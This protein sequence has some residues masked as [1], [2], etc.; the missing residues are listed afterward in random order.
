MNLLD[1]FWPAGNRGSILVTTRDKAALGQFTAGIREVQKLEEK[2][3]VD[4][5]M[6]LSR[7]PPGPLEHENAAKICARV[8]YLPLA[9]GA[10]AFI[11]HSDSLSFAEYLS[12]YS[13]RDLIVESKPLG[14][15]TT[16][17]AHSLASVWNMNFTRLDKETRFL[18]DT[19]AFLDPDK[20]QEDLVAEGASKCG[21]PHLKFLGSAKK[22]LHYRGKLCHSILVHRN[23]RLKQIWIQRLVQESCHIRMD[24]TTR[25]VAFDAA[26]HIV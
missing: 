13:N 12:G 24:K 7:Q 4:L 5:L 3:A 23:P 16:Q 20:I 14:G 22:F 15:P 18:L 8:D 26:F 1:D 19:L 6:K 17:Y 10:A 25:Q 2:D 9:I 21:D 11:I